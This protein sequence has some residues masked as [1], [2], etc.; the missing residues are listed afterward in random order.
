[1][2]SGLDSQLLYRSK[3]AC[4]CGSIWQQLGFLYSNWSCEIIL[5]SRLVSHPSTV[6]VPKIFHCA[7]CRPGGAS[8][9]PHAPESTWKAINHVWSFICQSPPKCRALRMDNSPQCSHTATSSC[10]AEWLLVAEIRRSWFGPSDSC[11][12]AQDD[13]TPLTST[14]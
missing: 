1:M 9:A 13:V 6:R 4:M 12:S 14:V 7:S 8:G 11:T 2:S 5:W 3:V 10:L